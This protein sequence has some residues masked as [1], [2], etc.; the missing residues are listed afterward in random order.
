MSDLNHLILFWQTCIGPLTLVLYKTMKIILSYK[1]G[2][3][4]NTV[5]ISFKHVPLFRATQ[6]FVVPLF[7]SGPL[8]LK[9]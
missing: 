9:L 2:K 3:H 4:T 5:I 1:G 6:T 7:V 8:D